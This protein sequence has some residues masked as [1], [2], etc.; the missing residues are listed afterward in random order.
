MKTDQAGLCLPAQSA[1]CDGPR[2]ASGALRGEEQRHAQA[3]EAIGRAD[4]AQ[5]GRAGVAHRRVL[6]RQAMPLYSFSMPAASMI[7]FHF[8]DSAAWKLRSS[9]GVLVTSSVPVGP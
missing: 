6:A 1:R 4:D 2:E 7:F 8:C 3:E 5:A 9:S